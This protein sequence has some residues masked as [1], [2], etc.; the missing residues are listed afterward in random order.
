MMSEEIIK[1]I[2]IF[3]ALVWLASTGNYFFGLL[4]IPCLLTGH[5]GFQGLKKSH[6]ML[7]SFVLNNYSGILPTLHFCSSCVQVSRIY[8]KLEGYENFSVANIEVS[9]ISSPSSHS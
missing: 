2:H 1:Y 3:K 6:L 7:C 8:T 4:G 5:A 9:G